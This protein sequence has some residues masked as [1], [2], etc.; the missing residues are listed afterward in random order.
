M[1]YLLYKLNRNAGA[2]DWGGAPL[3]P[4]RIEVFSPFSLRRLF[5]LLKADGVEYAKA[6]VLA[7]WSQ[8]L[9]GARA[10][11]IRVWAYVGA[12]DE[13]LHYS[14]VGPTRLHMPWLAGP[15]VGLEIGSC[16]TVPAAR[17]KKIYPYV[18]RTIS[19]Q[20]ETNKSIYMIV[21]SGNTASRAGMERAG[22]ELLHKLHR[23][24]GLTR[25]A[26]YEVSAG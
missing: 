5:G 3:V 15:D 6:V 4:G 11:E 25:P 18:L 16:I 10:G 22:F 26:T 1:D 8:I 12:S 23:R 20:A 14:M 9:G 24:P 13:I 17:G 2:T 19:E 21:E 7:M